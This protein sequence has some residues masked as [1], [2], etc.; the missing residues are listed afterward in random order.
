[1]DVPPST[2]SLFIVAPLTA[3]Q[4]FTGLFQRTHPPLAERIAVLRNAD[5]SCGKTA[6]L[7]PTDAV[8][9]VHLRPDSGC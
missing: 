3:G 9:L 2:A 4:V 6:G 8:V 7:F 5:P 1:M